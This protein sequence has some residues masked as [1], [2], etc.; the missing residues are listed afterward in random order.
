MK[1]RRFVLRDLPL[2]ARITL[3]AFLFSVGLGYISALVQ[4]H[5]QQAGPNDILPSSADVVKHFHGDSSPPKSALQ[6]LIEAEELL[7]FN[8]SGSMAAAFTKRSE[9]W[10]RAI[11]DLA[12]EKN[13]GEPASEALLR[14]ERRGERAAVLAWLAADLPRGDY[15]AD[16]FTLPAD[17]NNQLTAAYKDGNA[18]KIQSL[19]QDRCG[20]CHRKDGDDEK[21]THYP[22]ETFEQIK[23]YG[24]PT[25]GGGR[26]SLDKLAQTTHAHLLSFAVLFTFT[27]LLFALTNYPGLLRLILAPLVLVA[28]VA[29]I[30]CWW[31]A[32]LDGPLGES[33]A[34]AIPI[35]GA[36]VGI[37]L[38][39]QIVLTLWHLFGAFGRLLLLLIF[40][41]GAYGGW[42]AKEKFA[43]PFLKE[44]AEQVQK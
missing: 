3:A 43:D 15:D 4:L 1:K 28:Q 17:W 10:P 29:D 11:K 18:V 20:R 37:G 34:R 40:A 14:I 30:A 21:A 13:I 5:E 38:I 33:L 31:L 22:M 7:P 24:T 9:G 26:V 27:G 42:V 36:I 44:R 25:P 39:I 23:K 12:K 41:A 19:F 16:N 32:R 8:G 35:T 6:T 2:S